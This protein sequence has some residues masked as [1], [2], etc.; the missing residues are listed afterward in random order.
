MICDSKEVFETNVS[1]GEKQNFKI[2]KSINARHKKSKNEDQ[3]LSIE[4]L[5]NEKSAHRNGE[6]WVY[7]SRKLITNGTGQIRHI[8]ILMQA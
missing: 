8:R 2:E 6:N 3:K 5:M 1:Y 4:T 7:I